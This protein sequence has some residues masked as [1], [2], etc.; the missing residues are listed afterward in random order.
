MT[1]SDTLILGTYFFVLVIL[2]IYGCH[3]TYLVYQYMKNRG[4]YR[5][6]PDRWTSCRSSRFSF[7]FTTRCT[8]WIV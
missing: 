1:A 8:W 6:L 4:S 5:S 2:A 7:R 3:G